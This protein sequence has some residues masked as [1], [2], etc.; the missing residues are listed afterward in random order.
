MKRES[1]VRM[2]LAVGGLYW[3]GSYY[4][5]ILLTYVDTPSTVSSVLYSAQAGL[6][7]LAQVTL[8]ISSKLREIEK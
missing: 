6:K 8:K 2:N 3:F 1:Y 7:E 5:E 4:K